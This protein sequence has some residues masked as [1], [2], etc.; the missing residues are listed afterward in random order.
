[1]TLSDNFKIKFLASLVALNGLIL[2]GDSLRINFHIHTGLSFSKLY[3][4]LPVLIGISLVYLSI[5]LMRVKKTAL[6]A[7]IILY[8]IY[9][10]SSIRIIFSK[11]INHN[12][13]PMLLIKSFFI[14][15]LIIILLLTWRQYYKV[16]SDISGFKVSIVIAS[17]VLII[18][19]IY[20]T[21]GFLLMDNS[22]FHQELS[23]FTSLHY[24]LDQFNL[25]TTHPLIAYS[26]RAKIFLDSLTTISIGAIVYVI[27]ALFQPLK[28][29][30][31]DQNHRKQE[32]MSLM[33]NYP[34]H[35]EDYFK[36]WPNDKHYFIN[37][38]KNSILAY[39]VTSGIALCL[40]DP[41][42][43]S[44][45]FNKLIHD[46][47]N[48][49]FINDWSVAFIHIKND[50]K[51]IYQNLDFKLQK[52]G[53]EAVVDIDNFVLNVKSNKYFRNIITKFEKQGFISEILIPP[54]HPAIIKRLKEISDDWLKLPGRSER[55]FAMGY[56]DTDYLNMC[57]IFVI[58]DAANTIQA[59][60]NIVPAEFD[61]N[62]A[63][64]DLLRNSKDNISNINDYLL[65]KLIDHLKTNN[66][67]SLNLGLCP[68]VG[69]KNDDDQ[70]V[71]NNIL[72][73]AYSNGNRFYSFSGL[74]RFKAKYDPLW[75]DRYVAYHGNIT[76][77][78]KVMNAL[79]RS[80]K[81]K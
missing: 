38:A 32:L 18:A 54:H 12:L 1:M 8:V 74:Y 65:I 67:T 81:V 2:L 58:R 47:E 78:V 27:L 51:K 21:T 36:L 30:L 70:S 48:I 59:F 22:D 28:S 53:Q 19:I 29:R 26:N 23:F 41:I 75:R 45:T 43:K 49:C 4:T 68:L 57:Q 24:T 34:C 37:D 40:G 16:K 15:L 77:F 35:S 7:S 50:H 31:S 73:F 55:G 64:Y 56:F 17:T 62:E 79:V 76:G 13:L 6:I 80:M 60:S 52:I 33:E 14:P 20:G 10:T 69:L 3:L 42:G 46:F 63:T 11:P 9:L 25:T 44:T 66:Y 5:Q 39:K 72:N 61:K 71:I